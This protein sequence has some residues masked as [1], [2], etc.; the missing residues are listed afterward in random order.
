L[1]VTTVSTGTVI[2]VVVVFVVVFVVVVDSAE[3]TSCDGVFV[4]LTLRCVLAGTWGFENTVE[5]TVELVETRLVPLDNE[6]TVNL[7]LSCTLKDHLTDREV[8]VRRSV[9]GR[10]WRVIV[11]TAWI[12]NPNIV[13]K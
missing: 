5:T 11:V 6:V 2:V 8:L 4:S 7:I 9:R 1:L 3:S 10:L 13:K 12:F